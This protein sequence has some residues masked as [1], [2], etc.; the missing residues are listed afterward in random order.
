MYFNRVFRT[1]VHFGQALRQCENGGLPEATAAKY[2]LGAARAVAYLHEHHIIHRDIK[3]RPRSAQ[4]V[5][6]M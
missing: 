2:L 5:S 1:L 3:V 6:R 4:S